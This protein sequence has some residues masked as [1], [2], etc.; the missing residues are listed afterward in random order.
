VSDAVEVSFT[1]DAL[2]VTLSDD[3]VVSAPPEWFPAV[4]ANV[5]LYGQYVLNRDR[6]R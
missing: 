1:Q 6:V 4:I 2:V 3:Q 5:I